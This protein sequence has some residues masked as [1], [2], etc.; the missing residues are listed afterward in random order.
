M[1]RYHLK[2]LPFWCMMAWCSMQV[3]SGWDY[4]LFASDVT[5]P[6]AGSGDVIRVKV[7]VPPQVDLVATETP[8]G[9]RQTWSGPLGKDEVGRLTKDGVCV[10]TSVPGTYLFRCVIQTPLPEFDDIEILDVTVVVDGTGPQPPPVPPTPPNP[11]PVPDLTD[12]GNLMRVIGQTVDSPTR[13]QDA[14]TIANAF[15][16]T[17]DNKLLNDQ[18][19]IDG[20]AAKLKGDLTAEQK[21]AWEGWRLAYV[22]TLSALEA[23]GK[24]DVRQAFKEI[25]A[26]LRAV[27]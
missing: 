3:M 8:E 23:S 15:R 16:Y 17:A 1:I 14:Q 7:G 18:A 9:S 10:S 27:K 13:A 26:G 22:A 12:L 19:L 25:E 5:S 6:Q 20:V 11:D 4:I 2:W 24:L 21:K